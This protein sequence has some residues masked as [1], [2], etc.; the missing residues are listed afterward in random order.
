MVFS[1]MP[2]KL[3]EN[4]ERGLVVAGEVLVCGEVASR[5]SV[6]VYLSKLTPTMATSM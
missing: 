6:S 2:V 4:E 5:F 3:G 1:T